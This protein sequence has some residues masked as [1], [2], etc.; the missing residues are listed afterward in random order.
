MPRTKPVGSMPKRTA[1]KTLGNR[2]LT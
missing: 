1:A 2:K